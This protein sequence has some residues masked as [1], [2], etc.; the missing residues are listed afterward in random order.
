MNG[1]LL[2]DGNTN[3]LIFDVPTLVSY[4][5]RVCTLEPGDVVLTGTP[6]GVGYF[7]ASPIA[8]QPGDVV[9]VAVE[10]VGAIANPVRS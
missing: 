1:E 4:V 2:Q 8:L 7:R 6:D 5:S 3:D 9:E 10:R